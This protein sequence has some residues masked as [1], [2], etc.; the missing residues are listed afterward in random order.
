MFYGKMIKMQTFKKFETVSPNKPWSI[1]LE[2]NGEERGF[3]FNLSELKRMATKVSKKNKT[4]IVSYMT[5]SP[6][7]G[8][9]LEFWFLKNGFNKTKRIPLIWD[10]NLTKK[11]LLQKIM[12][13]DYVLVSDMEMIRFPGE[14]V[15]R[16]LYFDF[17]TN[18]SLRSMFTLVGIFKPIKDK[19]LTVLLLENKRVN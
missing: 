12:E 18:S 8:D 10:Y 13:T 17:I 19:S 14:N 16:D 3:M 1:R 2:Y 7:V 4:S 5:F 11:K 9:G 15:Y 6:V